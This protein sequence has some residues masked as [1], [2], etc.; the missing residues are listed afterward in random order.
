MPPKAARSA[1]QGDKSGA[2]PESLE[3]NLKM[4]EQDFSS[5]LLNA[6]RHNEEVKACVANIVRSRETDVY[7][8]VV[9]CLR[10]N[11]E[12]ISSSIGT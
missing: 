4:N 2:E 12:D 3:K 6:L 8:A 10:Q 11:H 9:N 1:T 7:S 5:M